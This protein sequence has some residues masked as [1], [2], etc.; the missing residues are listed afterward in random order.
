MK[1]PCGRLFQIP[2][3]VAQTW[4]FSGN[5][6]QYLL[7]VDIVRIC[8]FSFNAVHNYDLYINSMW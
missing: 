4:A 5:Y 1:I 8:F 6:I 3:N 2:G 7:L